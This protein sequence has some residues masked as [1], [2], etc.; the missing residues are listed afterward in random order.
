ML[1]AILK[2][3]IKY[4]LKWKV[5][6]VKIG[7]KSVSF[8]GHVCSPEGMR[9][10]EKYVQAILDTERPNKI[11]DL[12]KF[13]G[14][15]NW[16]TRFIESYAEIAQPLIA[17]QKTDKVSMRQ[18]IV[19]DEPKINAFNNIKK[20]L[21]ND[22]CLGFPDE[23]NTAEPLIL[24]INDNKN[25]LGGKL[26]QLQKDSK[27][28]KLESKV[29]EDSNTHL[30]ILGFY[31]C[32]LSS[33]AKNM[34]NLDKNLESIRKCLAHFKNMINE[35]KIILYTNSHA[36]LYLYKLKNINARLNRIVEE[37]ESFNVEMR[38][39]C[40]NDSA[41]L[42]FSNAGP[43]VNKKE[44]VDGDK[45]SITDNFKII[46]IEG[47][48]E[49]LLNIFKKFEAQYE[50]QISTQ[51]LRT[52]LHKEIMAKPG[53]YEI[54]LSET[55]RKKWNTLRAADTALPGEFIQAYSNMYKRIIH[56]YFGTKTP[57]IIKPDKFNIKSELKT[58][59]MQAKG[60]NHYNWL[61]PKL[62]RTDEIVGIDIAGDQT[63]I[64]IEDRVVETISTKS[65][66]ETTT[67]AIPI[68]FDNENDE[69]KGFPKF[70][71]SILCDHSSTNLSV[72]KIFF[73]EAKNEP[74]CCLWDTGSSINLI[75]ESMASLLLAKNIAV[76]KGSE[77]VNIA[78]SGGKNLNMVMHYVSTQIYLTGRFPLKKLIF[79]VM[80]D[81]KM[82]ACIIMSF[83][84]MARHG[85]ILNYS[86]MKLFRFEEQTLSIGRIAAD[87]ND[88]VGK[89]D[90]N[91]PLQYLNSELRIGGL[92]KGKTIKIK[93]GFQDDYLVNSKL[94]IEQAIHGNRPTSNDDYIGH[95]RRF[96][97][98]LGL[99]KCFKYNDSD[100][101]NII[102]EENKKSIQTDNIVPLTKFNSI[103]SKHEPDN[104][105]LESVLE[106]MITDHEVEVPKHTLV[107]KINNDSLNVLMNSIK[108][109]NGLEVKNDNWL[110]LPKK[111]PI[112]ENTLPLMSP[113]LSS[114]SLNNN[115]IINNVVNEVQIL[116]DNSL[117]TIE[118][119]YSSNIIN[120]L[121]LIDSKR[122]LYLKYSFNYKNNC[123]NKIKQ[124]EVFTDKVLVVTDSERLSLNK[125]VYN[126]KEKQIHLSD[127]FPKLPTDKSL[128]LEPSISNAEEPL[129]FSKLSERLKLI[130]TI[131]NDRSQSYKDRKAEVARVL[132]FNNI[133]LPRE[134]ERGFSSEEGLIDHQ[135]KDKYLSIVKRMI[136]IEPIR[137]ENSVIQ[138]HNEKRNLHIVN[139]VLVFYRVKDHKLIPLAS[140]D[141]IINLGLYLHV[142]EHEGHEKMQMT[143]QNCYYLPS[144]KN[145]M[146]E[147]TNSCFWCQSF[148]IHGSANLKKLTDRKIT[149]KH[150]FDLVFADLTFLSLDEG[151]KIILTIVDVASRRLW[152]VPLKDKTGIQ[153]VEAF[154]KIIRT[155]LNQHRLAAVRFDCGKEFANKL[156]KDFFKSMGTQI[157]YGTPYHSAGGAIAE[158]ANLVLKE[159]LKMKLCQSEKKNWVSIL[160]ETVYAYNKSVHSALIGITPFQAY[161]KYMPEID[162]QIP[163]SREIQEQL[164][165]AERPKLFEVGDL[166]LNRISTINPHSASR[167]L[168]Q[169]W[170]G[171]YFV[172]R[173]HADNKTYF[174][175]NDDMENEKRTTHK[176]MKKFLVP[177]ARVRNSKAF[178]DM[179][180]EYFPERLDEINIG[181][182]KIEIPPP[183][184]VKEPTET[185]WSSSSSNY[186]YD[187]G[188]TPIKVRNMTGQRPL[189]HQ[190][191]KKRTAARDEG[192]R[193][194]YGGGLERRAQEPIEQQIFPP[195]PTIINEVTIPP[196]N[197]VQQ[198]LDT[199]NYN[200]WVQCEQQRIQH[201]QIAQQDQFNQ[202]W[203]FYQSQS[204]QIP[205]L[206]SLVIPSLNNPPLVTPQSA[207]V[208]Q[209]TTAN[210]VH[211]PADETISYATLDSRQIESSKYEETIAS[212]QSTIS[213]FNK[214]IQ[215]MQQQ[216]DSRIDQ[217]TTSLLKEKENVSKLTDT[218]EK[219]IKLN[220]TLATE[221][222][223]NA[224]M[225]SLKEQHIIGLGVIPEELSTV[226]DASGLSLSRTS[227]D[228]IDP[229]CS[230]TEITQSPSSEHFV[231]KIEFS[232][233][234]FPQVVT[235]DT[236]S[237][238]VIEGVPLKVVLPLVT[239]RN[240][241]PQSKVVISKENAT[242]DIPSQVISA[243]QI[244]RA[245][246]WSQEGVS[247]NLNLIS[248]GKSNV[249]NTDTPVRDLKIISKLHQH[250][251]PQTA[252]IDKNLDLEVADISSIGNTDTPQVDQSKQRGG[253]RN[254]RP[255]PKQTEFYQ[256]E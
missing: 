77:E 10:D 178:D 175:Q 163:V 24:F 134:L 38:Y 180:H 34:G 8:L 46:L 21:M 60:G 232:Q 210:T 206:P 228:L 23:S 243:S 119:F 209:T 36:L 225:Y 78:G 192:L 199:Q 103:N 140:R 190:S 247:T 62:L 244:D 205:S 9:K 168:S 141:W 37:I 93:Q 121:K 65:N 160:D 224:A 200:N 123:N 66:V 110:D 85:I 138:Y 61:K 171:P 188:N 83:N 113:E 111:E 22:I 174:L 238:E 246:D 217:L 167:G 122:E 197:Y 29:I 231:S 30:R 1:E 2:R 253:T 89:I 101:D 218:V 127:N 158:T 109:A 223:Y 44:S 144:I 56:I 6:K 97:E 126:L 131:M 132:D 233:N 181:K 98:Y 170:E 14:S 129:K 252:S 120:K 237:S 137:W 54:I 11:S 154:K 177:T 31:S 211:I 33:T 151:K 203:N 94:E 114:E 187:T 135:N 55:D 226:S 68:N 149:A 86:S 19:W 249:L 201:W 215:E 251:T 182:D 230:P 183:P 96:R 18:T 214:T 40:N 64:I 49:N 118:C 50:N 52:E 71:N 16:I 146:R 229:I 15:V 184:P 95:Q 242:Y 166:V 88:E 79:G 239:K 136:K 84:T 150:T 219:L 185:S 70:E 221:Q 195:Q 186:N 189:K 81:E 27:T 245:L 99:S 48:G 155:D 227:P 255:N 173:R 87:T 179:R 39:I 165:D 216:N 25:S 75:S 35:K 4:N 116:S 3:M 7:V 69:V 45:Y 153:I 208:V 236:V 5:S 124:F 117:P 108:K 139:G 63:E 43:M 73:T 234:N 198:W 172:K 176:F 240:I 82:P 76:E 241:V 235:D 130:N 125:D 41:D 202:Q 20:S 212:L 107:S 105:F 90:F 169:R 51:A 161:Q 248:L 74:Y 152:A 204:C 145:L 207:I 58:L 59:S 159:R 156:V 112:I 148:K 164:L 147:I 53:K 17:M 143:L 13:L 115:I 142:T 42:N 100:L 104:N 162:Y 157:I 256:A 92:T 57:L 194:F 91:D 28:L 67:N 196:D 128:K 250:S 220:T 106:N 12:L 133:E 254:L 222:A 193:R 47:G 26:C 102:P 72:S 32:T 80:P 191:T 213:S